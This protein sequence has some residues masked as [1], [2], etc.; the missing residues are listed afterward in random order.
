[1][2][3]TSEFGIILPAEGKI[4]AVGLPVFALTKCNELVTS[5]CA[6][7]PVAVLPLVITCAE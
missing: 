1:M 5:L 7:V 2:L 6:I 3:I 4:I